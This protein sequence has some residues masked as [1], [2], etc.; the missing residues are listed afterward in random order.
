MRVRNAVWRPR[1]VMYYRTSPLPAVREDL[2]AAGFTV[3]AVA[4]SGL[5]RHRDGSS[6]CWLVLARKPAHAH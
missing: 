4:L 2:A 5:G 1:F 6:R 3:T